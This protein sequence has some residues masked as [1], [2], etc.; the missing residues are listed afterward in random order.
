MQPINIGKTFARVL[1]GTTMLPPAI[2]INSMADGDTIWNITLRGITPEELHALARDLE[3][4]I[5]KHEQYLAEN[6]VCE[7]EA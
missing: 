3:D 6:A 2:W 7:P 5:E 1:D 4:A